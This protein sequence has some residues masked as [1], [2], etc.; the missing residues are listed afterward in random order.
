MFFEGEI[1]LPSVDGSDDEDEFITRLETFTTELQQKRTAR[2]QGKITKGPTTTTEQ[3]KNIIRI[4]PQP[5]A[6]PPAAPAPVLIPAPPVHA[7]KPPIHAQNNPKAEPASK[8]KYKLQ[9]AAD[10]ETL[11]EETMKMILEGRLDERLTVKHMLAASSPL[12]AKFNTYFRNQRV[13]VPAK[14]TNIVEGIVAK[15]ENA[16]TRMASLLATRPSLFAK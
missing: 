5:N 1:T 9:S 15:Y 12:R 13:E 3:P 2:R 8:P 11:N 4:P 14:S 10:D 16:I 7:P 6:P